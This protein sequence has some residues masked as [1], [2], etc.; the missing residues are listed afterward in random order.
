MLVPYR[1]LPGGRPFPLAQECDVGY[2]F[3]RFEAGVHVVLFGTG[4]V[5]HNVPGTRAIPAEGG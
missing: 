3:L 1:Y 2:H 4:N 5:A